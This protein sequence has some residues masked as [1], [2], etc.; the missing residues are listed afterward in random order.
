MKDN[1]IVF[2][3]YNYKKCKLQLQP[4]RYYVEFIKELICLGY[5]ITILTNDTD[6][7]DTKSTQIEIVTIRLS[8][9]RQKKILKTIENKTI[10]HFIFWGSKKT[11][12]YYYL[13]KKIKSPVTIFYTGSFYYVS[14]INRVIKHL[15]IDDYLPYWIEAATPFIFT[16]KLVNSKLISGALVLSQRNKMR[17]LKA[18]VIGS[19][20][21]VGKV[22]L[23]RIKAYLNNDQNNRADKKGATIL[24]MTSAIRIR[25]IYFLL[26]AFSKVGVKN[27]KLII[28]ARGANKVDKSRLLT[29]AKKVGLNVEMLEIHIGWLEQEQINFFLKQAKALVMPFLL[30]PSEMPISI[31]DAFQNH[32]PVI[33]S[34][35]NGIP[36]MVDNKGIVY[37]PHK[38]SE[39]VGAITRMLNNEKEYEKYIENIH[40][41]IN[42]YPTWEAQ[43][44]EDVKLVINRN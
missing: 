26:K 31:L 6:I 22:G 14:E 39:L 37:N 21:F 32:I 23:N 41:Y 13:L 29:Y 43:M 19:K 5:K 42:Q 28:L 15:K 1:H 17:L 44:K 12:L 35:L 9:F 38:I 20:I 30:V 16:K 10:S 8:P 18:G 33:A 36:E 4:W 34:D 11:L 24:Y 40:S 27:K 2:V 3:I 25:G 7:Y